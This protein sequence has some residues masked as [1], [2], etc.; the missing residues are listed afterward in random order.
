MM[1]LLILASLTVDY[2][3]KE[4]KPGGPAFFCSIAAET[5]GIDYYCY[6][7][8]PREYLW[9][10]PRGIFLPSD[11]PVFEHKYIGDERISRILKTP[12]IINKLPNIEKFT[13]GLISPVFSEFSIDLV[14]NILKRIPCA[15]DLQGFV[16]LKDPNN[17]IIYGLTDKKI[18]SIANSALI[19]H[20][21]KEEMD[22]VGEIPDTITVITYGSK[23]SRIKH[24]DKDIYIPAYRVR[25]DPTGAGDFYTT[26]LL[27]RFYSTGDVLEAA[28]Y[29]TAA[30][31]LFI[32]GKIGRNFRK[33]VP[34]SDLKAEIN[35]R[36]KKI[37]NKI[38]TLGRS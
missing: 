19:V 9:E 4:K 30:T 35:E 25:G 10:R 22:V 26:I 24:E 27:I 12:S 36:T 6:G 31:S 7:V 38:E 29:A 11:G 8:M 34:I 20:A 13:I 14:Q 37:E 18:L 17:R 23:G 15:I 2:I 28:I 21:S 33:I 16:R 1:K 3:D 32:E 5:M